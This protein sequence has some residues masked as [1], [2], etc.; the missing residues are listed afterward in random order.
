MSDQL[1]AK[2]KYT[3]GACKTYQ[4][5]TASRQQSENKIMRDKFTKQWRNQKHKERWAFQS[6]FWLLQGGSLQMRTACS[7]FTENQLSFTKD[8]EK[9]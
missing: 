4:L 8:T 1:R 5:I 2:P 6:Y 9:E 3:K 7:L